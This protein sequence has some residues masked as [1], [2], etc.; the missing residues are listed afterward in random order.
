MDRFERILREHVD[1][2]TVVGACAKIVRRGKVLFSGGAG[3]ADRERGVPFTADRVVRIFSM[4]KMIVAAAALRLYE[5][6]CFSLDDPV[7]R[8]VPAFKDASV[9]DCG[10]GKPKFRPASKEIT[11]RHLFTMGAGFPY[12]EPAPAD[13]SPQELRESAACAK[14]VMLGM[15]EV[16]EKGGELTTAG[17]LDALATI[18]MCFEPG[19]GFLY[20]YCADILGGAVSAI[21]KK[22][23]GQF[24]KEEILA[25]LGMNDTTFSP[26]GEQLSRRAVLYDYADPANIVPLDFSASVTSLEKRDSELDICVGGM[27]STLDDYSR[28]IQMLCEGGSL[29]G[30]RILG[31]NTVRLMSSPQ[32]TGKAYGDFRKTW[33][34]QGNASWGL[35]CRVTTSVT[36]SP[37]AFGW[38]GAAGTQAVACPGGNLSAVLMTQRMPAD[39]AG[40][41]NK[42]VQAALAAG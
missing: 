28:F 39:S 13:G 23:L 15:R 24:L 1:D 18:P 21:A 16:R 26:D 36:D 17:M 42:L 25:P 31:R 10:A 9:I 38:G 35:M 19:E 41:F 20:G 37:H 7:S 6:G 14:R 12:P 32:L 34:P 8:F 33:A 40:L 4:T 22:P 5:E 11:M 30:K 3:M 2:G 27:Y 29:D